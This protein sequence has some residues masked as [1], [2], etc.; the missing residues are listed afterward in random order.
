MSACRTSHYKPGKHEVAVVVVVDPEHHEQTA[1]LDPADPV[2]PEPVELA[3]FESTVPAERQPSDEQP[4][5][6]LLGR[7][8]E[9]PAW[10]PPGQSAEVPP[11]RPV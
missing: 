4:P 10:L 7:P 1:E 8:P 9:R 11:E 6:Q 2:G 5:E 3:E